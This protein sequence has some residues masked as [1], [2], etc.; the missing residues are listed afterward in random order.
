MNTK[1]LHRFTAL[2]VFLYACVL[3]TL[4]VTET[5]AFW[6]TGEFIASVYQLQVMHPPGAPVYM[7]LG[8][9]FSMFVPTEYVAFAV[10][11]ISVLASAFTVLLTYL[12]IVRLLKEWT[13][14]VLPIAAIAG[15]LIGALAFAATD[16]FWYNAVE[17]EVYALAM[18]FTSVIVW[19]I[20]KWSAIAEHE[21]ATTGIRL[22]TKSSRYLILIAYLF[23]LSIGIHLMAL[24]AFFFIVLIV[25]FKLFD[26]A[27]QPWTQHLKRL[28][29]LSAASGVVFL[30][31]YPG[32]V[33]TLPA[34]A[35]ASGVP[36]FFMLAVIGLLTLGIIYTHRRQYYLANL[37]IVSTVALLIGY[38][39]IML[40][41]VRSAANPPIDLNNPETAE[42][43]VPY[44]QR[45]QY[46]DTPLLKGPTFNDRTKRFDPANE[47][48][49]PR[50]HSF[51]PAHENLYASYD[52][53]LDY[54]VRYQMGHMYWR[55]FM[56]NFVGKAKDTQHST[57]TAGFSEAALQD[58]V[59]RTPSEEA[60][61]NVYFALPLL[62]GLLG[63]LYHYRCDWRRAFSLTALFG[64]TGMGL[65]LYLNE[66]PVTPR[67]RDYI[68]VASFFAFSL[69]IGIGAAALLERV[70]LAVQR[71]NQRPALPYSLV[72]VA[73]LLLFLAVP[74]WMVSQNY[75]D[76]DRSENYLARD[77]AYNMLMSVEDNAIIFTEGDNDTYPLWY[78]Q[79]VEGIRR[80]V[81]VVCL[82][83]LNT[84][85]YAKQLKNQWSYTSAPLPISLSDEQL[86]DIAVTAWQPRDWQL[87]VPDPALVEQTEL[88]LSVED[89][90]GFEN[91]MRWTIQGRPYSNEFNLLYVVDQM[92]LDILTQNA[93]QGW[94]RPVYFASTTAP[95]SQ[96]DL[97]PY[98]QREGLSYRIVPIRHNQQGGRV[99][100]EIM[101]ERLAHFRFT[102]LDDPTIYYAD[103]ARGFT[104]LHY[105]ESFLLTAN[106]LL[107]AGQADDAEEV[108]ETAMDAVPLDTIPISLYNAFPMANTFQ[109][110]GNTERSLEIMR[111]IEPV[112]INRIA[113]ASSTQGL[114]QAVQAV[115]LVQANYMRAGSFEEASTLGGEL[116]DALGDERYRQP[117]E[118]L[119]QLFEEAMR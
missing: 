29:V 60:S 116:A 87:P 44:L 31:L 99:V 112:V 111:D 104:G 97:Q 54:F 72:G 96:L 106:A 58:Y 119:Q 94:Q 40:L 80:D 3:Y 47:I 101:Q 67:E 77:F 1:H 27:V 55:Y 48:L 64:L 68:Y 89:T 36:I 100:P 102:N 79:N 57:W 56:W 34:W 33:I 66:I 42:E 24:L 35:D 105:R 107:E 109:A 114:T 23:G 46:G 113:T 61:R 19:L 85:W 14:K 21:Y 81:R 103:D 52:S 43:L 50:R 16:S 93:R 62:L 69:W 18:F 76:H 13:T 73:A 9:F 63:L 41:P 84:P 95:S 117:P 30:L 49:F 6:D 26:A 20:L 37:A 7:L 4:T 90:S 5:T 83:L 110:L 2:L 59:Y 53:D 38:S 82:S 71:W 22:G 91:P 74:G 86:D 11:M 115:Q 108:L 51:L 98:F 78:L 28:A 75:D 118:V 45:K 8:R 32:M 70:W 25:Y 39:S 88:A 17:A 65:V 92:V 15:G 10:N 12:I